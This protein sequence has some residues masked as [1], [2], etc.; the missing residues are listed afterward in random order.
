[1]AA[2]RAIRDAGGDAEAAALDVTDAAAVEALVARVHGARGRI[3]YLFNNAGINVVVEFR[4]V[5][6]D[7]WRR[8][9]DVNLWGVIHGVQAAYPRMIA[10]GGGVIV[11]TASIAG[12][13]PAAME[14]VYGATKHAVVGLSTALRIEAEAFGVQVNAICPGIVR[15]PMIETG[16]YVGIPKERVI[17]VLAGTAMPLKDAVREILEGI[18]ANREIIV[19]GDVARDLHETYR[20]MPEVSAKKSRKFITMLRAAREATE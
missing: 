15:T 16:R 2:A 9:I 12:L 19:V 10:Q 3:D 14:G 17:P 5:T 1:E 4:D 13:V 11:N 18:E 7:D 8:L 6:L 20:T